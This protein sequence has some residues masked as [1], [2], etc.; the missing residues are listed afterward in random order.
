MRY[1]SILFVLL[2]RKCEKFEIVQNLKLCKIPNFADFQ[3]LHKFKFCKILQNAKLCTPS[4]AYARTHAPPPTHT[5]IHTQPPHTCAAAFECNQKSRH[6]TCVC[7]CVC[8]SVGGG[9]G[10]GGGRGRKRRERKIGTVIYE[11]ICFVG[12]ASSSPGRSAVREG[13]D[14]R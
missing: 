14:N 7:M 1:H 6:V 4:L 11:G 10:K 2:L 3:I 13:C 8:V 9:G 5:H 12:R